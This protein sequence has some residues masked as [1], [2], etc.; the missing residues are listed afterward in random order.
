MRGWTV[1][2]QRHYTYLT[3]LLADV[4]PRPGTPPL[5]TTSATTA[6]STAD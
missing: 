5:S 2:R 1:D 3:Q 4:V 6:S